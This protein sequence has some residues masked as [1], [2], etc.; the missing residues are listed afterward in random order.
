MLIL[1]HLDG[2]VPKVNTFL[3][4]FQK[5]QLHPT[6]NSQDKRIPAYRLI[7]NDVPVGSLCV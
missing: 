6:D 2:E 4:G 7:G 3:S 1:Q 5:H